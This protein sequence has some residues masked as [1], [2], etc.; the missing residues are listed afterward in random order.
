MSSFSNK[1]WED[2]LIKGLRISL[3][4]IFVWFGTLKVA[5]YN[6]VFEIVNSTF[7]FFAAGAGNII[8]G[9]AETAIGVGLLFNVFSVFVHV[10]LILHLL[11][12]FTT[13]IFAPRLMFDPYFPILTF[14]GEFVFK[15]ATLAMAG[16]VVLAHERRWRAY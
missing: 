6:P 15:N 10:I 4:L 7:P 8:L 16:L 13:F 1:R 5:G 14:S 3:G 2:Y 12:T 11:G 9:L